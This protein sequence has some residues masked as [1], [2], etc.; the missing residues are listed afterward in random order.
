M[1]SL[2]LGIC[3]LLFP[4]ALVTQCQQRDVYVRIPD[5]YRLVGIITQ[6]SCPLRI[7]WVELIT[8][9]DGSRPIVRYRLKNTSRKA[10]R[11]FSV[12]I[13]AKFTVGTWHTYGSGS[14]D[15]I[16]REDGKGP[17]LIRP[18]G[19]YTNIRDISYG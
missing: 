13:S 4:S 3:I 2:L 16:G 17:D 5:D 7:E 19:T 14:E 1:K 12:A 10:I 15:S 6:R 9:E 11:F 18:N 8:P